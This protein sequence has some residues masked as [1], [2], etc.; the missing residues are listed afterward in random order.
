MAFTIISKNNEKTFADKELVNISSKAGYDF[1]L[2]VG[3]DFML[4][5][6][7]DSNTNQC[8]LLNQFNNQRFLF[9]G[10]PIPARLDINKICKIMID[11]T[12]EF[13][14]IKVLGTSSE[15]NIAEENITEDDV[16]AIYG[17]GVNAAAKLKIEKRKSEL[18]EAR[19][20]IIKDITSEITVLKNKIS[21]NSKGGILLHIALFLSSLVCAFGVSNYLTGLPLKEA[22]NVIQMPTNMKLIFVY[23]FIIYG[24]GLI[25]KQGIY[26]YLQNKIGEDS[27]T[28]R[29]AEKFMIVLSA[30]FY[31][32][33]YIINVLYYMSA[34]E[35][36][37]FAVLIS[38]F[39]VGTA[40]T[41]AISCGDFKHNSIEMR[42][43]L[44]S[45]EYRTDFEHV[46]KEYQQWIE[47]FC[48]NLSAT[49]IRNIKDKLFMLQLKTV[50]EA[51]LGILTAPFL[52]YGVSNTLAMCF[53][54]AAGWLRISG[55]RFSP[56]FLVLATFLIIFA[57]FAFANAFFSNKKIQASNV[58]KQDGFSNYIQHGVEIY[59]IEGIKKLDIDMRRSFT[60]GLV[61]VF[62]EF[63]MNVSYFMQEIG[64]DLSGMLLSAIAA[65]VPTAL[66]IAETYMLSQTKFETFACEELL[67]K[68][69]KD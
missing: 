30:V 50:G 21:M 52:A 4:A 26:S 54:E 64:G 22:A 8:T 49:K 65:L 3:F 53:P 60:I 67:E 15:K 32:T 40:A 36:P 27:V 61:I 55:L 66:L 24:I 42:K 68:I 34:N 43:E 59:G 62:I 6:Q 56:I 38:L 57:F 51:I 44:N 19:V 7:Y 63:S 18:E 41:I 23:S 46:I 33:I 2:D 12:D 37:I 29:I 58:L 9:K 13:I 28:S 14:T 17:N 47:R 39:F 35:F 31:S 69:D 16:K 25:L 45:Y 11:G 20:A 5:V 48:N 10:K 1:Q